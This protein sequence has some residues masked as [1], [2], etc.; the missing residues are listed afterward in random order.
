M[1]I[2]QKRAY[3]YEVLGDLADHIDYKAIDL[4]ETI[5][6]YSKKQ[7]EEST[8]QDWW[9]E[10]I[11]TAKERIKVLEALKKELEKL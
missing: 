4:R 6:S 9:Q 7:E 1:N 11:E 10:E 2:F 8:P 3:R 5:E